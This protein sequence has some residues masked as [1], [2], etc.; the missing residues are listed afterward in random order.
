MIRKLPTLAAAGLPWTAAGA[1]G[2]SAP[3]L[4]APA[5]R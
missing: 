3:L 4:V 5:A 2:Y 1:T